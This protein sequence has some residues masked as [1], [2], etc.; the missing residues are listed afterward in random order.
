MSKYVVGPD[1]HMMS[2]DEQEQATHIDEPETTEGAPD[3]HAAYLASVTVERCT[4]LIKNHE[5]RLADDEAALATL[6]ADA[7]PWR[8]QMIED[9]I[10]YIRHRMAELQAEIRVAMS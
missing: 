6:R 5:K 8:R 10:S 3:T 7:E 9:N 2:A 1:G 4:R